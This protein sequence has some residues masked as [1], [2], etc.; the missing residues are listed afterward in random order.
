MHEVNSIIDIFDIIDLATTNSYKFILF[1][2]N[3]Q[4]DQFGSQEAQ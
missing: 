2:S 4:F 3:I 1:F